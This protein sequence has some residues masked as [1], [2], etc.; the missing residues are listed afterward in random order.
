MKNISL[1]KACR[2][3]LKVESFRSFATFCFFAVA[4]FIV[5]Y[6]E[7]NSETSDIPIGIKDIIFNEKLWLVVLGMTLGWWLKPEQP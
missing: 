7:G 3:L 1:R 2:E 4:L 6:I 5:I